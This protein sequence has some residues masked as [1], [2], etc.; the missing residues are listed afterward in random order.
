[1]SDNRLITIPSAHGVPETIGLIEADVKS[2]GMTVFARIDHAAG[3]IDRRLK[4]L[5]WQDAAGK[6]WL[7]YNDPAWLAK[8]HGLGRGVDQTVGALTA[9]LK[10]IATKAASPS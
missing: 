3:G 7:T 2:K 5:A 9:A 1:M 6:N 10:A 4:M 8:R